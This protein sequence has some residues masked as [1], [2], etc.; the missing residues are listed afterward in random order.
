MVL[1]A[2][3]GCC[4]SIIDG[5]ESRGGCREAIYTLLQWH[6]NGFGS[7][8]RLRESIINGLELEE[9]AVKPFTNFNNE[10]LMCLEASGGRCESII[11]GLESP[12]GC[13]EA[14]YILEF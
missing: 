11:D 9:A 8:R 3:S 5:L 2:S 6:I 12:R 7:F 4:E 13:S 14:I 10:T 1:G